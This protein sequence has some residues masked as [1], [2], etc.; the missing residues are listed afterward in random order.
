MQGSDDSLF[1]N[2]FDDAAVE[3]VLRRHLTEE[4]NGQVGRSATFFA[5]QLLREQ[6]DHT[7]AAEH[8][9]QAT[10]AG[11]WAMLRPWAWTV[12]AG[13]LAAA[14]AVVALTVSSGPL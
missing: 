4:L 11:R 8:R 9:A 5:E 14:A 13:S 3:T 10:R 2:Q 7:N 12:A 6:R 1:G